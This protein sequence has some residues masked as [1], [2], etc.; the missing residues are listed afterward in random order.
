MQKAEEPGTTLSVNPG[1]HCVVAASQGAETLPCLLGPGLSGAQTAWET[2][3]S[4]G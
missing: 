1:A 4:C 2:G 3:T